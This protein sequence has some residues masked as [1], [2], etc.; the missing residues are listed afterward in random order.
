[1]RVFQLITIIVGLWAVDALA[2]EGRYRRSA[3]EAAN[4]QGQKL[5]Y[6]I[7]YWLERKLGF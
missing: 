7:N 1:M 4:Y 5:Q 3:W 6:E 2:F